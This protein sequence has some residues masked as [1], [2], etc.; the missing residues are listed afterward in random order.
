MAPP[1]CRHQSSPA[2]SIM[3]STITCKYVMIVI[4]SDDKDPLSYLNVDSNNDDG[5]DDDDADGDAI[6]RE[7]R[8]ILTRDDPE[9]VVRTLL[10]RPRSDCDDDGPTPGLYAYHE[11]SSPKTCPNVRATR[12]SMACGIFHGRFY[13]NVIVRRS[14]PQCHLSLDHID[15]ACCW[16]PD[17]RTSLLKELLLMQPSSPSDSADERMPICIP[18][19]L[20]SAAKNNY[21]D[22]SVLQKFAAVM[23]MN[24][25]C[26]IDS[27]SSS[28]NSCSSGS[29][30]D[31]DNDSDESRVSSNAQSEKH[32]REFVTHVPLCLHCRR[33]AS[34]LCENCQGVYFCDLPRTCRRDG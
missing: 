22:E 1:R 27:E 34:T 13:G 8:K 30:N 18:D 3:S 4:P 32:V 7:I 16:S 12:L 24:P 10:I 23:K 15:A 26:C 31:N 25:K 14:S 21:H 33:P 11:P 29:C 19:W 5:D 2:S 6:E 9:N 28:S 17:L 20:A